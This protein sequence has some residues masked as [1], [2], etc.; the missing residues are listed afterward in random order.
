MAT[1]RVGAGGMTY[2]MYMTTE[3]LSSFLLY[4]M[5]LIRCACLCMYAPFFSSEVFALQ[6]RIALAVAFPLLL[7]GTAA[8]TAQVPLNLE[9]VD[10]LIIAGQE[11]MLGMSICFLSSLIFTGVQMA[12][13]IAGQQIGFSMANVVDPQSGIEVPMLGFINMNLTLMLFITAKL[14]LLIIYILAKSYEWIPVGALR[15]AVNLN[16]PV[17]RMA[18]VQ[19]AELVKLGAQMAIPIMMIMLMNSVVE[20]FVTKTMPQMNIQVLGIPLRVV[21]GLS[22]LIFVYP[23]ICMAL[24]PQDWHYS[25]RDLIQFDIKETPDGPIGT[26]LQ[27]LSVMVSEMGRA[28]SGPGR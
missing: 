25:L 18:T 23:A 27:Q 20:G 13:E 2:D 19:A 5:V 8:R 26:M 17:Y 3:M 24:V 16:Y 21:L 11:F 6:I 1:E 12:G 28:G 15:P 4:I 7:M 10:L 9:M 22:T 14:H